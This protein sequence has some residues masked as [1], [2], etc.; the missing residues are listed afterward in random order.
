MNNPEQA[1]VSPSGWV[2]AKRKPIYLALPL[3]LIIVVAGF[4]FLRPYIFEFREG[5]YII[6]NIPYFGLFTQKRGNAVF[7]SDLSTSVWSVISAGENALAAI[8]LKDIIPNEKGVFTEDSIVSFLTKNGFAAHKESLRINELDKYIN[9]YKKA[10]LLFFLPIADELLPA[11]QQKTL[12]VVVGIDEQNEKIVVHSYWYGN[13][14]E[15]P[16]RDVLSLLDLKEGDSIPF[17]VVQKLHA[18]EQIR[19]ES[20]P[21][22]TE[23]MEKMTPMTRKYLL[24]IELLNLKRFAASREALFSVI[25]HPDFINHFPP[26][27]KVGTYM[28][29]G[30][31]Y[32]QEG[33]IKNAHIYAN[34]SLAINKNLDKPVGSWPGFDLYFNSSGNKGIQSNPYVFL[35][36]VYLAEQNKKEA[37]KAF[38]KALTIN[39]FNTWAKERLENPEYGLVKTQ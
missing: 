8:S 12:E 33:D 38:E 31:T 5:N 20:Y 25:N 34:K 4:L 28:F 24:G 21:T 37:R 2:S 13:N 14:Y 36:D 11:E 19:A 10:P 15:I 16:F 1:D 3:S 18:V 9:E 29:I 17:I 6:P 7:V 26:F 35:G 32:L 30:I 23:A 39:P 27:L 22:R